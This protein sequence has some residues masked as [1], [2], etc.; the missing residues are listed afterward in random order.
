MSVW[1]SA[2][3]AFASAATELAA[4]AASRA[5]N[6]STAFLLSA[7]AALVVSIGAAVVS[8]GELL[9]ESILWGVAAGIVGGTAL[10]VAYHALALGPIGVVASVIACTST[11]SLS[12]AGIVLEGMPPTAVWIGMVLSLTAIVFLAQRSRHSVPV[13]PRHQHGS[14]PTLSIKLGIVTGLGFAA[15][16]LLMSFAQRDDGGPVALV[17]ARAAVLV[18]AIVF[19][20]MVRARFNPGR[21]V[22]ASSVSAGVLDVGGNLFLLAALA[23]TPLIVVAVV[24]ATSP[25]IAAAGALILLRERLNR[26][27][28]AGLALAASGAVLASGA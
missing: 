1:F 6:V 19:A 3:Y 24:G 11:I 22:V 17:A 26:W 23:T 15:F 12:L 5:S 27:Q 8:P 4:G 20:A 13:S 2:G 16:T 21:G 7:P 18:V 14:H 28:V 9:T 10:P 25:A